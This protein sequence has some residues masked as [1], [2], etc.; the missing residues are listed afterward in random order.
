MSVV[1]YQ[2][3]DAAS[4]LQS[5]FHALTNAT[6]FVT[7][8]VDNCDAS[9]RGSFKVR[10]EYKVESGGSAPTAGK[11]VQFF[12]VTADDD[13]S[14]HIDGGLSFSTSASALVTGSAAST[15]REQLR[16]LHSQ[17]FGTGTNTFYYGS[18][19]VNLIGARNWAI[20]AYNDVG[21]TLNTTAANHYIRW[22]RSLQE[23]V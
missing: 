5:G 11:A 1:I 12:L 9:S 13:A 7:P 23:I 18:F 20:Y 6:G 21:Q 8:F 14:Q 4:G 17:P 19:M 3:H 15:V 16:F 2:Q 22:V 10:V